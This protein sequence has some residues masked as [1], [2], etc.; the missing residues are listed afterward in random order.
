MSGSESGFSGGQ[1]VLLVTVEGEG[2]ERILVLSG[3]LDYA[4]AGQLRAIVAEQLADGALI[5][6][7]NLQR[8]AFMDLGGV[9]VLL[10]VL[11]ELPEGGCLELVRPS[12]AVRRLL[13]LA[14]LDGHRRLFGLG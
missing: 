6:R 7:L 9:R 8:V 5:L 4:T 10:D 14:G 3:T 11:E 2:S 13:K 12:R 1:D